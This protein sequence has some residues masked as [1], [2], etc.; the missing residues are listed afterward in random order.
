MEVAVQAERARVAGIE[1]A[2]SQ[3][4][5]DRAKVRAKEAL[6]AQRKANRKGGRA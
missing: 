2:R 1:R 3:E 5:L 4:A 6:A